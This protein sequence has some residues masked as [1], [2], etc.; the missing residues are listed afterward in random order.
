MLL[1]DEVPITF[2]LFS[3]MSIHYKYVYTSISFS[4]YMY[5][6]WLCNKHFNVFIKLQ[7]VVFK[8]LILSE[9]SFGVIFDG[10]KAFARVSQYVILF[11][12]LLA[13]K[14]TISLLL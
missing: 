11:S 8:K 4:M 14:H 12:F 1:S 9:S 6:Y 10:M 13:K 5:M 2:K 7:F 3:L